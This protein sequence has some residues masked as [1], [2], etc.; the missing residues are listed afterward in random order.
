MLK[1][2]T[3]DDI[4]PKQEVKDKKHIDSYNPATSS[5]ELN[6][7]WKD[8]GTGV[9]ETAESFRKSRKFI[10]PSE[11]ED[12]Y[13]QSSSSSKDV[14]R[15]SRT[16]KTGKFIKPS[17]EDDYYCRSSSSTR[18]VNRT[19]YSTKPHDYGRNSS[20]WRK[21][22]KETNKEYVNE[23]IKVPSE[24]THINRDTKCEIV[25]SSVHQNIEKSSLYLSDEKMNK[26][27]AK[28]V[29]AEIMGNTKLVEE[30]RTKLE[31]AREYRKNNPDADKEED[32]K[33]MLMSTT[34]SGNSRPLVSQPGDPRSKAGK[35]KAETHD[36]SGRVKYFGND[37][38]Y[39]LAQMVCTCY[40]LFL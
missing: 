4:K 19:S 12:F 5:R 33:V 28:I 13:S 14:D 29:K 38:R 25:E 32:D 1:T 30:L 9:P 27:A 6:P 35:R 11:E 21:T 36:S 16:T 24:P 23:E 10:K 15:S 17:D 39:D 3:K 34:S 22:S 31:A 26:L 18:D 40:Y 20:S 7:Y 2:Y 37:D 8:G